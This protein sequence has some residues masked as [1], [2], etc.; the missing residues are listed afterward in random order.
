MKSAA[1]TLVFVLT[2]G[3]AH[4][5]APIYRCGPDGRIYSQAPCADGRLIEAADPRSA[6]QRAE[7]LRVASKERQTAADMERD[8][9]KQQAEQPPPAQA[10][11]FNSRPPP[12]QPAAS[13]SDSGARKRHHSKAKTAS[14]D[15][16]A[17][18]PGAKKK[19]RAQK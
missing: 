8:R 17:I 10:V 18:D 6:A 4:A 13:S 11:G 16:V 3:G 15:F 12:P 9:R 14:K 7:A 1:L 19:K 2:A 5:A